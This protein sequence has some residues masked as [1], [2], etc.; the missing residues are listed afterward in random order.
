[1]RFLGYLPG[2]PSQRLRPSPSDA[3]V[4][5][6]TALTREIRMCVYKIRSRTFSY[7]T[8]A[9]KQLR[10]QASGC[11]QLRPQARAQGAVVYQQNSHY[12]LRY[13]HNPQ[14]P[15]K[16]ETTTPRTSQVSPNLTSLTSTSKHYGAPLL[17]ALCRTAHLCTMPHL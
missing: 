13:S 2:A 5:S 7:S 4:W 17:Y 9:H 3:R 8:S 12:N 1:M 10:P 15:H 6:C 14:N 11:P 16:P